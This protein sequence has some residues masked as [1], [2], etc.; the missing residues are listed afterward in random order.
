MLFLL[1]GEGPTDLGKNILGKSGIEFVPGPMSYFIDGLHQEKYAYSILENDTGQLQLVSETELSTF[2]KQEKGK[3]PKNMLIPGIKNHQLK[4]HGFMARA[5]AWK[6]ALI[7]QESNEDCVIPV[8]FRDTDSNENADYQEKLD[9]INYGFAVG[10]FPNRGVAMLPK[11]KSEAWLLCLADGYQNGIKYEN[12]PANDNAPNPLKLQLC[13]KIAP[14]S[15][16]KALS[17]AELCQ[18]M[19]NFGQIDFDRLSEELPSF[20]DFVKRFRNA[21]DAEQN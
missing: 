20:A 8:F 11:P 5:L 7:Q 19:K 10:G 17:S 9:S 2:A 18:F 16:S 13:C 3:N 4:P 12:G 1:S 15:E 6:A 21:M 14:D